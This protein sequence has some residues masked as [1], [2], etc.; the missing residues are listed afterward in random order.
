MA[1][2]VGRGGSEDG[3]A[4][5]AAVATAAAGDLFRDKRPLQ[6][7]GGEGMFLATRARAGASV[8]VE[9]LL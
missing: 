2:V 8:F 4:A 5:A 7:E 3:G 9:T 1:V 6:R